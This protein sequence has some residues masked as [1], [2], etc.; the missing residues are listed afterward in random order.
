[1]KR[2]FTIEKLLI[3]FFIIKKESPRRSFL[4]RVSTPGGGAEV[5]EVAGATETD[6]LGPVEQNA[7]ALLCD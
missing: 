7:T 2:V 4:D 6:G 3:R 5:R 1:M